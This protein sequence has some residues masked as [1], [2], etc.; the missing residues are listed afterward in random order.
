MEVQNK[1]QTVDYSRSKTGRKNLG[2][3]TL[4]RAILW[5]SGVYQLMSNCLTAPHAASRRQHLAPIGTMANLDLCF[6]RLFAQTSQQHPLCHHRASH[7]ISKSTH[8]IGLL[9]ALFWWRK[10]ID[11]K[12]WKLT[13][14]FS[15]RPSENTLIF[16]FEKC[17][18]KHV[19]IWKSVNNAIYIVRKNVLC[20]V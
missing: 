17:K 3:E 6:P 7:P 2:D 15:K 20:T 14:L 16:H 10:G 4:W 1:P 19:F 12:C 18:N 8:C 9:N 11:K 5:K 13:A